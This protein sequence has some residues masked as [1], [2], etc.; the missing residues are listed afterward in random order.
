GWEE[1]SGKWYYLKST[2]E[3]ATGWEEVS[4]YWYF[5]DRT[6]GDMKTGIFYADGKK[7]QAD[8]SGRY[9]RLVKSTV[10]N[11]N[12]LESAKKYLEYTSFSKQG[13]I[14]Q[15]IFEKYTEFEAKNAVEN[16]DVNWKTQ[17]FK[18]AKKYLDYMSFSKKSLIGQLI[19][20]KYTES[21]AKSAVENLNISWKE[22]AVKK[23]KEYLKYTS[24][25]K[26]GL[27]DQLIFD[28]FSL[29]EAEYGVNKVY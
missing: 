19:F 24:F 25:S 18:S 14:D 11:S 1:V 13:L 4:G 28:G 22:Q 3:M 29:T 20:D 27:I 5:L 8:S 21:E 9:L 26:Q 23:A 6:N 12:A 15:L 7:Y 10:I 2:G 17:A 16:L